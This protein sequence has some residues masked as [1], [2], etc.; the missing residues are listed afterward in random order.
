MGEVIVGIYIIGIL[1]LV[2][3]NLNCKNCVFVVYNKVGVWELLVVM[4]NI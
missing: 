3:L 4:V 1:K 2:C